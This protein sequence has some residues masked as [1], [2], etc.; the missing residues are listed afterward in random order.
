MQDCKHFGKPH[1]VS[2]NVLSS[3]SL[4]IL[5]DGKTDLNTIFDIK[6]LKSWTIRCGFSHVVRF[7]RR[8]VLVFRGD[9][10]P[11]VQ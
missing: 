7:P 2:S 10:F 4:D 11:V 5:W 3:K 6:R 9:F 8:Y 1:Q